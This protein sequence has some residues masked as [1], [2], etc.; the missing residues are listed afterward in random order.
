[1]LAINVSTTDIYSKNNTKRAPSITPDALLYLIINRLQNFY[2][3]WR[4]SFALDTDSYR[5]CTFGDSDDGLCASVP[6]IM[7]VVAGVFAVAEVAGAEGEE[8]AAFY[9][10]GD[11]VLRHCAGVALLVGEGYVDESH[12]VAVGFVRF[13]VGFGSDFGGFAGGYEG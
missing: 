6:S 13:A 11:F 5:L 8:C 10:Y 2:H 1:M 7:S 3:C 4:Q 12:I 9:C